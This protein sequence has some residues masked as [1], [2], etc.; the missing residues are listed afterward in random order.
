[1]RETYVFRVDIGRYVRR[2]GEWENKG[3]QESYI[4][5]P[6]FQVANEISP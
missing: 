2:E 6:P 3:I 1:M 4:E 5:I